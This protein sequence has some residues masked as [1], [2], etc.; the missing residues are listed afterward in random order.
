VKRID[1]SVTT[2]AFAAGDALEQMPSGTKA[3]VC[4][5]GGYFGVKMLVDIE[6]RAPEEFR[7][8]L[9]QVSS[10][11]GVGLSSARRVKTRN[12]GRTGLLRRTLSCTRPSIFE[13][14]QFVGDTVRSRCVPGMNKVRERCQQGDVLCSYRP[15]IAGERKR[16]RR[17]ARPDDMTRLAL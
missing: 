5:H 16:C 1:M 15:A 12:S 4:C 3:Y 7:A 10:F 9:P 17:R 14:C 6:I 8:R 11:D 13:P 2:L